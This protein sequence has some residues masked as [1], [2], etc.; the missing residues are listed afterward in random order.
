MILGK[1]N[2]M[3]AL[4]SP[5][6][7]KLSKKRRP[8]A[9]FRPQSPARK[10]NKKNIVQQQK[11][12]SVV[13]KIVI[14]SALSVL[15]VVSLVTLTKYNFEHQSKL[16]QLQSVI[17]EAEQRAQLSNENFQRSFG[18]HRSQELMQENSYKMG[19]GQQP[20]II[21]NQDSGQDR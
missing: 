18:T 11:L 8:V 3:S 20:I 2:H 12:L 13:G 19:P 9:H 4:P 15:G 14:Y 17:K 5:V 21:Y 16:H 10:N 6:Q 1:L 7:T